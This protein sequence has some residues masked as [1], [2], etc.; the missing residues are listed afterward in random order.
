MNIKHF[1]RS[2]IRRDPLS[3]SKLHKRIVK[4][5]NKIGANIN[6][7]CKLEKDIERKI[8]FQANRISNESNEV[9]IST[10]DENI[11]MGEYEPQLRRYPLLVG[12]KVIK[13][14]VLLKLESDEVYSE[15]NDYSTLSI[16]DKLQIIRLLEN[17]INEEN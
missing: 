9:E 5:H 3:W 11:G 13:N 12:I 1:I 17:Y 14:R 4:L 6:D 16:M 8:Y 10:V 2:L 7:V 15:F